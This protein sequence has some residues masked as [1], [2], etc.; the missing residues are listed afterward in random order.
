MK[1]RRGKWKY[2]KKFNKAINEQVINTPEKKEYILSL[3]KSWSETIY[4]KCQLSI[5]ESLNTDAE[6]AGMNKCLST[7]YLLGSDYFKGLFP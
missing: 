5:F 2:P 6:T 4:K 7:E 3:K 1:V